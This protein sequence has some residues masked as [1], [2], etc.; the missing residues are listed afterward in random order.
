MHKKIFENA[1]DAIYVADAD[2]GILVDC[3]QAACE[4]VKR[5]RSELIGSHQSS[6]HPPYEIEDEF[7]VTFKQYFNDKKGQTLETQV[8]TKIGEIRDV[9]I[10]TN[11]FE[12]DGKRLVHG[13]FRDLT[14]QKNVEEALTDS[15]KKY[16]SLIEKLSEGIWV[17]DKDS[18]TSFVNPSM[19]NLLGYGV[20]EMQGK[21]LFEFMDERGVEIYR[22]NMEQ[23]KRGIKDQHEFELLRKDGTR[24]FTIMEI[25]PTTDKAGNYTGAIA[26]VTDIT[27]R[28]EAEEALRE[29]EG[30]LTMA[31]TVAKVGS[32]YWDP[33]TG[34]LSWS[35]ETCRQFGIEPGSIEPS[36]E[37]FESLV[38]T[39]DLDRVN[40]E[41]Q[42]ALEGKKDYDLEAR[43]FRKDGTEWIM[44]AQG[45]VLRDKDDKPI[46]F[47]GT[48]QDITEQKKA[49]EEI[50]KYREQ[51]EDLV[52]ERTLAL[53]ESN[54]QLKIKIGD[55][56]K[57]S[58]KFFLKSEITKH[59]KEGVLLTQG[60][61]AIIVYANRAF[62]H[63]FRYGPGEMIGMPARM[64]NAPG[65]IP[66]E[67][68]ANKIIKEL[69]D[70]G[71]WHGEVENIKKDGTHFWCRYSV[72]MF[73]HP[74]LGHLSIAIANDITERKNAE[75]ELRKTKE[76][77]ALIVEGASDGIWD[78]DL[79]TGEVYFS[80]RW[81]Q[82]L[83]YEDEEF[84]DSIKALY[85]IIHPDDVDRVK[86][87]IDNHLEGKV[88]P[89]IC[90]FRI[91]HKDGSY[92]WVLARGAT[93]RDEDGR[94]LRFAGSHTDITERKLMEEELLKGQRLES[95]GVLA[96]GI[97]H[98]FN[99]ILTGVITNLELAKDCLLEQ[100][101]VDEDIIQSLNYAD[102]AAMRAV[103]LTRQLL[104]F[105]KGGAPVMETVSVAEL[106]VETASF[107][108]RGSNVRRRCFISDDL[109][110]AEIDENQISQVINNL[111]INAQQ[112][113]P[114][115]GTV[116][117]RA[118][119]I[120]IDKG[121]LPPL[122]TGK[123]IKITIKD[124]GCGI[125]EENLLKIF[126][127]YFTTKSKGTG[128]GLATSYTIVKR[129]KGHII[130]ESEV[131]V[132]TS[133]IIYLPAS[134]EAPVYREKKNAQDCRGFGRVLLLEDEDIVA[135]SVSVIASSGGYELEHARDG[136]EA[137]K[138]YKSAL[139]KGRSFDVVM[140]DLTI[141][142][143]MGGVETIKRL[144]KIDPFIKAIV[145]SGYSDDAVMANYS[146]YGFCDVLPKPFTKDQVLEK[147]ASV[148]KGNT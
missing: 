66:P 141:A 33:P 75:E 17:I 76:R 69:N 148:L 137:V 100:G 113:M 135:T 91:R 30:I 65:N 45:K 106:L 140:M 1:L 52:E 127:P 109:W 5:S 39:D 98:D 131:G 43:M 142:G 79:V 29:S 37:I 102:S 114:D 107:V 115:G 51:L 38:H 35:D 133:F 86:E 8:I 48:Q 134:E 49:E 122:N 82:M 81:K 143:G 119:N 68:L 146:E 24:V 14:V 136:K 90:E 83:G 126:D 7:S 23:R 56:K 28:K 97:A 121:S 117:I 10:K 88:D 19:A 110:N 27:K 18:Y 104:T 125:S 25:S 13:I 60:P 32:W 128:L 55:E 50:R 70:T 31:Q 101:K 95:I 108:L 22:R 21:H 36:F 105:S 2:S 92:R 74:S 138:F 89:Y 111:V 67:E 139:K 44:H 46:R 34:L 84:R 12:L 120:H 103:D 73:E 40:R 118:E 64:L 116:T 47:V 61:E 54:S 78:R 41:V 58:E 130:V 87:A 94:P 57:L 80:S 112:S 77:Y 20:D 129:H 71:Q 144:K 16:S 85:A 53:E 93:V 6:L 11:F 4:L 72:S 96:G 124:R 3:N 62:E 147:L 9:A 99:N 26:G 15:E 63:N 123:Y 132:G 145:C 42:L 59:M